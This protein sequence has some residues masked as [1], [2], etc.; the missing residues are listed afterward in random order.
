MLSGHPTTRT[1]V[2]YLMSWIYSQRCQHRGNYNLSKETPPTI[3][4]Y[5][6]SWGQLSLSSQVL[7]P[8]SLSSFIETLWQRHQL[9]PE[10]Y[11][12]RVTVFRCRWL[13]LSITGRLQLLCQIT[14]L[15]S[16][17]QGQSKE[18]SSLSTTL[19]HLSTR[20]QVKYLVPPSNSRTNQRMP[21]QPPRP[22]RPTHGYFYQAITQPLGTPKSC[23][24]T[25]IPFFVFLIVV[26]PTSTLTAGFTTA[27]RKRR[28]PNTKHFSLRF[29]P[30]KQ[31]VVV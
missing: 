27:T 17:N 26:V 23:P 24:A 3:T 14:H 31:K 1:M 21:W 18:I 20:F 30:G 28:K 2:T 10:P 6:Y 9:Q 15:T 25:V 11:H 5:S 8:S 13:C 16:I 7:P 22:T 4:N 12:C 29:L 19:C